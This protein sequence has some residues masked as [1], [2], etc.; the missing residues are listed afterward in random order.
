MSTPAGALVAS[1]PDAAALPDPFILRRIGVVWGLLL[2]NAMPW[3]SGSLLPVPRAASKVLLVAALGLAFVLALRLNP[4]L[5]VR[6]NVVLTLATLLALTSV[7]TSI[8]GAVGVGGMFRSV[9]LCVFLAV[10]WLL[11]PWWGRRDL[12]FVRCHLRALLV[13]LATVLLGVLVAP[14]VALGGRLSGIIWPIPPPQVAEYAAVVAGMSVA[15]WMSGF[16]VRSQAMFFAGGGVIII[17]LSH[18]RTALIGLVAGVLCAALSLALSRRRVRRF[19]TGALLVV[20]V[21]LVVLA[22]VLLTWFARG[23]STEEIGQLTGR[24]QVWDSVLNA[25]RSEFDQWFG[26]GLSDKAF[27]GLPIDSTWLAVYHDQGLVGDAVVGATLLFLLVAPIFRPSAP[28]RAVVTFTVVY[29]AVAAYT[30]VGFGDASPYLLHLVVAASLLTPAED[31]SPDG[32][33]TTS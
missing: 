9:R 27:N 6:P 20:P 29:C 19:L 17:L 26:H 23:Q 28:G 21:V 11:T 14:T 2:A 13:V 4:R 1:R 3:I 31:V 32:D 15:L 18:T 30:E 16:L 25:P 8:R 10:L 33:F 12:L 7:M 22:P 24:K 5:I